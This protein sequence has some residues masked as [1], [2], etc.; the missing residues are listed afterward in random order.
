MNPEERSILQ[1]LD[2][3]LQLPSVREAIEPV[4]DRV[5]RRLDAD[6]AAVMAWEP[7]PLS[8]YPKPLPAFIQSSWVFMLR[9]RTTT[10]AERHPNSHQRMMSFRGDGDMQT[11]G[12]GQWKSNPL[13]SSRDEDWEKRWI[14]IPTNVW[15]QCVVPDANWVVVSFQTVPAHEL[16]EERP[17]D[18]ASGR[19]KQ[20]LYVT[21]Q[22][23]P[24]N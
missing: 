24:S 1:S 13:V 22:D 7:L 10:G 5:E 12:P 4:V 8:I 3:L 2:G 11:G 14:S 16:I 19:T 23:R 20:R 15:H 17:D 6:P 9:A 21:P 18:R